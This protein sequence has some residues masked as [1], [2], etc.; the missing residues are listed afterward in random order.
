VMGAGGIGRLVVAAAAARGAV[1]HVVDVDPA[2]LDEALEL[3]ATTGRLA[4]DVVRPAAG[5]APD[6]VIEASGAAPALRSALDLVRPGGRV[7]MLGLPGAPVELA[8][9]QAVIAEVDLRSSSA[10]VC[11]TDIPTALD[12]LAARRIDHLVV[13]RVVPLDQVVE[14]AFEPMAAGT[15]TGKAVISI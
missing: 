4:G 10:H 3:G 14:E 12:V 13:E 11:D 9:R 7:V 8:V 5:G 15:L 2:R 1:V 6:V